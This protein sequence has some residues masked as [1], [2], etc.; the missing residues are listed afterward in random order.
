MADIA[1]YPI[2]VLESDAPEQVGKAG[3]FDLYMSVGNT[4]LVFMAAVPGVLFVEGPQFTEPVRRSAELRAATTLVQM[5]LIRGESF[6][7]IREALRLTQQETAD[8]IGVGAPTLIGWEQ[9][10]VGVPINAWTALAQRACLADG[11]ALPS[12]HALFADWRPRVIRIFP[13]IPMRSAQQS[14]QGSQQPQPPVFPG[15][16]P[17]AE[18]FPLTCC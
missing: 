4:G 12:H 7:F 2:V 9:N 3:L 8:S 16:F 18:C 1:E 6:A 10:M 11:R 17:G 15:A 13:N 14:G 5:G